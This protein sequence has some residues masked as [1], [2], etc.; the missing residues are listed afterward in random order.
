MANKRY[1]KTLKEAKDAQ[2]ST[3]IGV[4]I[5]KVKQGRHKGYF[6]VGTALEW[7]SL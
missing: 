6:F 7:F 5:F 4:R 2:S 1:Y 3:R